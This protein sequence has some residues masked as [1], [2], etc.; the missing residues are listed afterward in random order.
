MRAGCFHSIRSGPFVEACAVAALLV[1]FGYFS[2]K[3]LAFAIVSLTAAG[4]LSGKWIAKDENWMDTWALGA[5][6]LSICFITLAA[7]AIGLFVAAFFRDKAG[8][9]WYPVTIESFAI[10]AM[11]IGAAEEFIFRGGIFGQV[12]QYGVVGAVLFSTLAH[13]AYKISI[14]LGN[15]TI[16][17]WFLLKWTLLGGLSLS[18]LRLFSGSIWPAVASHAAFDLVLY[19][20]G[21][22]PWWVW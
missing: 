10:T 11:F 17:V 18:L 2:Q 19:G 21:E 12:K 3:N 13:T 22:T 4:F 7:S 1:L 15:P 5:K 16:D 9:F 8:Y 20:D 6:G 14:F